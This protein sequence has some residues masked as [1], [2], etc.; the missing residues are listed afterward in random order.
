MGHRPL[1]GLLGLVVLSA[2]APIAAVSEEA[3]RDALAPGAASGHYRA[4]GETVD[5]ATGARRAI[6]GSVT[7]HHRG[8]AYSAYFELR[9]VLPGAHV[10]PIEAQVVGTGTGKVA[11]RTLRGKADTQILTSLPGS[12]PRSVSSPRRLSARIRSRSVA[13]I[14]P[15]GSI[16]IEIENEP[17]PGDAYQPTQTV[18]K[19]ERIRPDP[20]PSR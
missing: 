8:D 6:S 13:E 4:S 5:K 10:P 11:G 3:G 20:A 1:S 19:G 12:D 7:V 14:A 2:I 17:A 16:S 18:L 15:D 9:T